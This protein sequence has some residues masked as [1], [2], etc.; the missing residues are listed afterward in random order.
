MSGVTML[1]MGG[2]IPIKYN[3]LN[4]FLF[5]LK[6]RNSAIKVLSEQT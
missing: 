1:K 6:K 3:K 2:I 5:F 4:T